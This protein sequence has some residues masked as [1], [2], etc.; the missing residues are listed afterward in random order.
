MELEGLGRSWNR[1]GDADPRWAV[2]T[3]PAERN[4]TTTS[5]SSASAHDIVH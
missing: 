4:V 1:L 5:T 3:D 2:L